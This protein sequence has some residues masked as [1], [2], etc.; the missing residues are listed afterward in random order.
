MNS[1]QRVNILT[2]INGDIHSKKSLLRKEA[3]Y[4]RE[5]LRSSGT[6]G[7]FCHRRGLRVKRRCPLVFCRGS[8]LSTS[9]DADASVVVRCCFSP[10]PLPA[11]TRDSEETPMVKLHPT[12][13]RER[14][15]RKRK[16]EM[17]TA[18]LNL[19]RGGP[20]VSAIRVPTAG[21]TNARRGH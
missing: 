14:R 7:I 4:S 12:H 21:L 20:G 13:S 2:F 9:L 16:L 15:K 18:T 6:G 10:S 8:A 5:T 11:A 1:A 3:P 19:K 17:T